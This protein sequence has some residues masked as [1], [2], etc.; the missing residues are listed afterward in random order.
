MLEIS[1]LVTTLDEIR[2]YLENVTSH[3][4]YISASCIFH[5]D[6][7]PSL[8]VYPDG[9]YCLG[10]FAKGSLE[11]LG[12][13]L[14][15]K[16]P[17]VW[18]KPSKRRKSPFWGFLK[19]FGSIEGIVRAAHNVLLAYPSQGLYLKRRKIDKLVTRCQLGWLDGWYVFPVFEENGTLISVVMRASPLIEQETGMR[20]LLHGSDG[21]AHEGSL[22]VP[23]WKLALES[24]YVIAC[25]G[26]IDS[27]SLVSLGLPGLTWSAGKNLP[28]YALDQFR[29]PIYV[30]PDSNEEI[31]GYKLA[32]SL[33]WRGEAVILDYPPGMK[34]INDMV[35]EGL[36]DGKLGRRFGSSSRTVVGG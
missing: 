16:T 17:L 15:G 18:T 34:D 33:G 31:D 14:R 35:M 13:A 8:L 2:P 12:K 1:I 27:L 5:D 24:D 30:I 20:Y 11:R 36:I 4:D 7:D 32:A 6:K 9:Y 25:Y 22:Y 23:D 26:I 28:A 10:C 3:G 21:T 19:R 29:K